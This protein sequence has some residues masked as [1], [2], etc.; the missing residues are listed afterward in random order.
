MAIDAQFLL[1]VLGVFLGGGAVQ[2]VVQL[3]RRRSELRQINTEADSVVVAAANNQVIRLESELARVLEDQASLRNDLQVE[4]ARRMSDIAEMQR[5]H[6]SQM[7]DAQ[8]RS[9]QAIERFRQENQKLNRVV[10]K[11][12]LDLSHAHAEINE[13]KA[14]HGDPS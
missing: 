5:D 12:Q 7:A 3:I 14:R 1:Q 4:R 2:L 8:E 6:S 11:L 9:S 13:L 10:T